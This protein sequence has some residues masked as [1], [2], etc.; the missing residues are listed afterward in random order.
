MSKNHDSNSGAQALIL[1]FLALLLAAVLA[2]QWSDSEAEKEARR[3]DYLEQFAPLAP[4][5][6]ETAEHSTA[7]KEDLP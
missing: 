5:Y 1:L 6:S 4:P 3:Y 7:I 2:L